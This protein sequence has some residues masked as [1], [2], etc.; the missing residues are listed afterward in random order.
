[1]TEALD[2]CVMLGGPSPEREVSL[3]SGAAVAESLREA[4]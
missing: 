1:M 3:R 2:I 4:G